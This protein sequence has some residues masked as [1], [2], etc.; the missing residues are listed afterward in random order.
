MLKCNLKGTWEKW[1]LKPFK[2]L[3]KIYR[4]IQIQLADSRYICLYRENQN[5]DKFCIMI[6]LVMVADVMPKGSWPLFPE[7]GGG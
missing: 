7:T 3:Q 5:I 6:F 4:Y 1:V 2:G